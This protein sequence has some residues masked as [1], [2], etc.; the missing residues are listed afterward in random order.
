LQSSL[1][2]ENFQTLCRAIKAGDARLVEMTCH[3]TGQTGAMICAVNHLEGG[4]IELV[5]FAEMLSEPLEPM[6]LP[7]PASNHSRPWENN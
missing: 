7:A 1:Y 6:Q 3:T 4:K 2:F 5:P